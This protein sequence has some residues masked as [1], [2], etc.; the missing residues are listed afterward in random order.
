MVLD[1]STLVHGQSRKQT[2]TTAPA[3][4]ASAAARQKVPTGCAGGKTPP[5]VKTRPDFAATKLKETPTHEA[6]STSGK[7]DVD[8]L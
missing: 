2:T 5:A 6:C 8:Q 4:D 1:S 7:K 3:G